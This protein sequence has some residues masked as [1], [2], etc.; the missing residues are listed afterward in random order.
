[1]TSDIHYTTIYL[2]FFEGSNSLSIENENSKYVV[3]NVNIINGWID[4]TGNTKEN[5]QKYVNVYVAIMDIIKC[6]GDKIQP[7]RDVNKEINSIN[8]TFYAM[9]GDDNNILTNEEWG[10]RLVGKCKSTRK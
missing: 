1:M 10:I 2:Y 8:A 9:D 4:K 6:K 5:R 3:T 7:V